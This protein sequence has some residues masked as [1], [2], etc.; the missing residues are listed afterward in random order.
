MLGCV[1]FVYSGLTLRSFFRRRAQF[2]SLLNT[3]T[4]MNVNRYLRL[5][6]L[7]LA[8]MCCTVPLGIY[9]MYITSHGIPLAPWISWA[10][11]HF[12][13]GRV[14]VVP[15]II[16]RNDKAFAI[17]VELSRWLAPF[18]AFT[19][20]ALFGFASEAKKHYKLAFWWCAKRVG[21]ERKI[22]SPKFKLPS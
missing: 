4:A 6:A 20:F 13:F 22:A 12:D 7:A 18:C 5:M 1:S 15:A 16:W 19:F 9:I 2:T 3:T 21:Y 14:V 11:T 17:T 8:D 10:D